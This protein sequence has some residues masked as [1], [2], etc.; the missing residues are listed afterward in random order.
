MIPM[1]PPF[2]RLAV[3]LA[4]L[5]LA[6]ATQ[7]PLQ[8]ADA[9]KVKIDNFA[10]TPKD[11]TVKVGTTVIFEND[12]DIPH[13]VVAADN[14]FRSKALDTGDTYAFTFT[15]LG[16]VAYFCGLHPFMQGKITVSP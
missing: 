4:A 13:Q 5:G 14:S 15:T 2:R 16:D 12:D 3:L 7:A 9:S 8:A 1:R 6:I 11:L 10:F